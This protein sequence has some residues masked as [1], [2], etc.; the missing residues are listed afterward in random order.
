MYIFRRFGARSGV[1]EF[2]KLRY[3]GDGME[4]KLHLYL[5]SLRAGNTFES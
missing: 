5:S 3:H 4:E 1:S 2:M